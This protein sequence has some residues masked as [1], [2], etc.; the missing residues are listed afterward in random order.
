MA[1]H[2]TRRRKGVLATAAC[3][4]ALLGSAG[5]TG[6][7]GDDGSSSVAS[8]AA[9]AAQSVGAQ[10]TAAASSLASRASEAYESATAEVDRR[11]DEIKGGVDA[12]DDVKLG[13]PGS[14]GDRTTVE[15][16]VSNSAGSAKSFAV[17]VDFED[18]GGNR[19]D[20]VFV[21][22]SDVGAGR[23][24]KATARSN[25]ELSGE[26]KAKAVRAVRY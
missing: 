7:S 24:G 2:R 21:T 23:T 18:S 5:L 16:T 13:P 9:S 1:A 3:A 19:L 15:V 10:A 25:R 22:V 4:A 26:V 12:E 17:Q 11:F 14:E 8:Q 20:T 6:C